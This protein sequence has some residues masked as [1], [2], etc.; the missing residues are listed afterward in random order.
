MSSLLFQNTT[1]TT[2]SRGLNA[3]IM[4]KK[5][6]TT[7]VLILGSI[8]TGKLLVNCSTLSRYGAARFIRRRRFFDYTD[9]PAFIKFMKFATR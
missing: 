9:R 1:S 8:F 5:V 3:S 4:F 7:F 6:Y 2:K